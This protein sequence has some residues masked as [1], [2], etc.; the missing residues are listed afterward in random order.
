MIRDRL[1]LILSCGHVYKYKHY[2]DVD[3]HIHNIKRYTCYP[4]NNMYLILKGQ[5]NFY[6]VEGLKICKVTRKQQHILVTIIHIYIQG[7]STD[8][9]HLLGQVRISLLDYYFQYLKP[10]CMFGLKV[11]SGSGFYVPRH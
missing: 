9:G 7:I 6:V 11:V 3:L 4:S 10:P 2:K 1:C 8:T 5:K